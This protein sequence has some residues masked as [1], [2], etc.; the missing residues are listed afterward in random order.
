MLRMSVSKLIRNPCYNN[1]VYLGFTEGK[2]DIEVLNGK[3][4]KSLKE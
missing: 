3:N 1:Y 2:S 4:L